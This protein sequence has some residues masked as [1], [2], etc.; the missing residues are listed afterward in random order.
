VSKFFKRITDIL[1]GVAIFGLLLAYLAPYVDPQDFWPLSFFGL[2]YKVWLLL[3]I[4]LVLLWLFMKKRRWMYNAFFLLIGFQFA[5]RNLQ[6]NTSDYQPSDIKIATFNTHV[7][8]VYGTGN[9]TKQIDQHLIDGSYD[10]AILIEWLDKKGS[11]NHRSFPYQQLVRLGAKRNKH[12]YGLKVV[13]KYKIINW[14]RIKYD[15]YTSNMAAYFDIDIDGTVIRLVAAHLQ[16][17]RVSSADYHKL[18]SADID[19]EYAFRFANKLRRRILLRSEQTKTILNAIQDSP[20]PVMIVG[21][22]N[23]TP[24]SY[25]YQQLKKG[26]KD[27]FIERGNGW[28]ATYLKPFPLLRIDYVLHDPELACTSYECIFTVPSDHALVSTSFRITD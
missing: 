16:S 20:Y 21:D 23:D 11:V 6:Y 14:E 8:N 5:T 26:R 28:G 22:F 7:Q 24:Q 13:S 15:H 19:K 27:A 10:I 2:S 25:T 18:V 17:N 3:N 1:N 9:T 12:D 4:V